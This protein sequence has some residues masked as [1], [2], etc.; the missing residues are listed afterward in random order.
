MCISPRASSILEPS[1]G[2]QGGREVYLQSI[3]VN[4][5]HIATSQLYARA[6]QGLLPEKSVSRTHCDLSSSSP[7]TRFAQQGGREAVSFLVVDGLYLETAKEEVGTANEHS[8]YQLLKEE[9]SLGLSGDKR[10]PTSARRLGGR[11]AA[12]SLRPRRLRLHGRGEIGNGYI[13]A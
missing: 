8:R 5:V 2:R 9:P 13:L 10:D 6:K 7:A 1:G 12:P 11:S 4:D 3:T